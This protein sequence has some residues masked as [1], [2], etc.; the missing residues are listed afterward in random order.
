M[1]YIDFKNLSFQILSK[2]Q[3]KVLYLLKLL[4]HEFIRYNYRFTIS[5]W[6]L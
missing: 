3:I 4:T 6:T 5:F 1:I 2:V